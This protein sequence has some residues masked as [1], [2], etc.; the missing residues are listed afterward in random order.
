MILMITGHTMNIS[1]KIH[2][3]VKESMSILKNRKIVLLYKKGGGKYH[4]KTND[5]SDYHGID[6]LYAR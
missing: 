4:E 1:F 5:N 3:F 2:C 6:S